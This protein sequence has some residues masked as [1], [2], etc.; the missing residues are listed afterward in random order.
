MTKSVI[1]YE[2][3]RKKYF[4]SFVK[5][6]SLRYNNKSVRYVQLETAWENELSYKNSFVSLV[7]NY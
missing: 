3:F 2:H 6:E 4:Q 7:G 1:Y 5:I